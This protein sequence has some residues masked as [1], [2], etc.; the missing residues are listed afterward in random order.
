MINFYY[1]LK[2][3]VLASWSSLITGGDHG[4]S[5]CSEDLHFLLLFDYPHDVE[6]QI[7]LLYTSQL[8]QHG[9]SPMKMA[10]RV[11]VNVFFC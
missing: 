6:E 1:T 10:D 9:I 5:I 2:P 3:L 11:L 7:N 4:F 8:A